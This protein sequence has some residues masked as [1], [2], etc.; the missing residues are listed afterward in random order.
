ML[1]P[2]CRVCVACKEPV[3]PSKILRPHAP[4]SAASVQE[5]GPLPRAHEV[6]RF[7]WRIFF[8]I[9]AAGM[10]GASVA[11]QLWGPM[12]GQLVLGGVP[13]LCAVWVFY[14]AQQKGLPKPLRWGLWVLLLWIIFFPWYLARRNKRAAA[15]PFVEGPVVRQVPALLLLLIIV[16]LFLL[17]KGPPA[18]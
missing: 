10:V 5:R 7:P 4:A 17:I 11:Q 9:F 8:F 1:A 16:I 18:R 6:V 12:K 3:D 2:A 13:I 15:C 14:D